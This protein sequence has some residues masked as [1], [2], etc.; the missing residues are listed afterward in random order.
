MAATHD[1]GS[2]AERRESSSLSWGTKIGVL[3]ELVEGAFLLRRYSS[4]NCYHWFE[5]N[6]LRQIIVSLAQLAEQCDNQQYEFLVR[7][8][9][10]GDCNGFQNHRLIPT[11][12]RVP[13]L[14]P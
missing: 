14:S 2:C 5:S 3:A 7:G 4:K 6:T 10:S 9:H 13:H 1:L 8:S 11:G 12:V